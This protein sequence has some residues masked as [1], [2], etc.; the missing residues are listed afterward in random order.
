MALSKD[1]ILHLADLARLELK[2]EQ[3]VSVGHD[4][5]SILGY[6]KRLADIPTEGVEPFTQ[7][8]REDWRPDAAM[9]CDDIVRDGIIRNFPDKQGALLKTPGVFTN[10]KS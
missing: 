5:D 4:L 2:D 1:D 9:A 8:K 3:I 7:P 6:V 10:P